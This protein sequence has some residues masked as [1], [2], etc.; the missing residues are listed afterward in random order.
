[1]AA[2]TAFCSSE[3]RT[4]SRRSISAG[5]VLSSLP[6]TCL[7]PL[8]KV[9]AAR[10]DPISHHERGAQWWAGRGCRPCGER[11]PRDSRVRRIAK[12]RALVTGAGW[13]RALM[14]GERGVGPLSG[15]SCSGDR[16]RDGRRRP[17]LNSPAYL[18]SSLLCKQAETGGCV[19]RLK[20]GRPWRIEPAALS[21]RPTGNWLAL[22]CGRKGKCSFGGKVKYFLYFPVWAGK[23]AG[24]ATHPLP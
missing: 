1:M 12:T 18:G 19:E 21:S 3:I 15:S 13:Q 5:E 22:P 20:R 11:E 4:Y 24:V 10:T 8:S 6:Q 14:T 17:E 2:T 9:W 7:S 16:P 23:W